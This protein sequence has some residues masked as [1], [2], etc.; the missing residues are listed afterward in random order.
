M[1]FTPAADEPAVELNPPTAALPE[2]RANAPRTELT[3]LTD[4]PTKG[5]VQCRGYVLEI[6]TPAA[7]ALPIFTARIGVRAPDPQDHEAAVYVT[8]RWLGQDTVA[9]VRPGTTLLFEGMVAP[10]EGEPTIHNPRYEILPS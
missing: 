6:T 3:E 10:R 7:D 1:R 2:L 5:R 4:L 8:L 9:G